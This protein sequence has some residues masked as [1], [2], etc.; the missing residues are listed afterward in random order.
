[1]NKSSVILTT[2]LLSISSLA[3]A[4]HTFDLVPDSLPK[5][6]TIEVTGTVN[7]YATETSTY[8]VKRKIGLIGSGAF[9]SKDGIVLSC[10]HLFEHKL[11]NREITVIT[12]LG[13]TY[14]ALLL[15]ENKNTDLSLLKVFPLHDVHYFEI[16]K[17][18]VRGQKVWAFGSPLEFTRTVS[19]GYIEN[20]TVGDDKRT[21]RSAAINPGN[22][23]GPLVSEDGKLIGVNVSSLFIDMF[24]RAEGM[25][26]AV[27][28]HDIKVFL[29][30]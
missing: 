6:V 14:R 20:L 1:M 25:E 17:P 19:V 13:K 9:I 21:L 4:Q 27:S 11:E 26:Q 7:A 22:S 29:Q 15:A 16:G 18:V 24:E 2:L 10:D 3:W 28:L 8:T 30:E 5:V 12:M 23:G